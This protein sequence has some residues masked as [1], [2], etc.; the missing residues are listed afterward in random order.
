MINERSDASL[1]LLL[2]GPRS[3]C[4]IVKIWIEHSIYNI[5]CE[6][7]LDALLN[8]KRLNADFSGSLSHIKLRSSESSC[9]G[10]GACT[11]RGRL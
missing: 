11:I 8:L 4:S 6:S 7:F 10:L 1:E 9:S 5:A 2:K 3:L